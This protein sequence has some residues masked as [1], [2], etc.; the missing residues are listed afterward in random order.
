M[1]IEPYIMTQEIGDVLKEMTK[2][3]NELKD[4]RHTLVGSH[5]D[6]PERYFGEYI[7]NKYATEHPADIV[8][9][10]IDFWDENKKELLKFR[11]VPQIIEIDKNIV[12]IL[13][14][15]KKLNEAI[16]ETLNTIRDEC[17]MEY[18]ITDNEV[19]PFKAI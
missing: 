16:F 14:Q 6:E 13:D 8:G 4:G 3:F 17:R 7:I 2:K 15:L 10:Q 12:G 18:N 11:D 19:E 1:E 9:P 5:I